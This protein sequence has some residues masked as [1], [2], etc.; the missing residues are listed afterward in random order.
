MYS[1]QHPEPPP[2]AIEQDVDEDL[3]AEY[4]ARQS[5]HHEQAVNP[6][7]GLHAHTHASDS[8]TIQQ[9]ADM[10]LFEGDDEDFQALPVDTPMYL[11]QS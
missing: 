10:M 6:G 1:T 11:S 4:L 3:I 7:P 2:D 5:S 9:D 8:P